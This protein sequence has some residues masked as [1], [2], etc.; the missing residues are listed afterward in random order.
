[1]LSLDCARHTAAP[2]NGKR[3]AQRNAYG[4]CTFI[5]TL[6]MYALCTLVVDAP[7]HILGLI[8]EQGLTAGVWPQGWWGQQESGLSASGEIQEYSRKCGG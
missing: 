6:R 7:I 4:S 3:H 5:F 8:S 1:M 2:R